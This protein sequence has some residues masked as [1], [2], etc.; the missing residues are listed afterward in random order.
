MKIAI[1]GAGIAGLACAQRLA[2]GGHDVA[3]FERSDVPG[4]RVATMRTELGG[5]D[6][7][8]QYFTIR[9]PLFRAAVDAW[10]RAGLV[11]PWPV[12]VHGVAGPGRTPSHAPPGGRAERWV[13]VPGMS[14]IASALADGIDVRYES[15]IT[16]VDRDLGGAWSLTCAAEGEGDETV[17]EGPFDA[18]VAAVPAEAAARWLPAGLRESVAAVTIEPC[19]AV[20]VGFA[21]PIAIDRAAI[22]DAA[23]VDSGRLA[24]IAREASKPGRRPGERWTLHAPSGWSIEHFD[25]DR[26][27]VE[28][29][30]VTAFHD[31]TGTREQPIYV[32]GYRWRHALAR[33]S[34]GRDHLWDASLKFG[35]CGD[36]CCGHRVEDAWVSG[37]TLAD[38]IGA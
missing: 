10:A 35:A 17:A 11:A 20:M 14:A 12:D 26:E 9:S 30:L 22:G 4:G 31:V 2:D 23:F 16:S 25:D 15:T 37:R 8:A 6:H 28:A 13:G 27:D 34:L 1:V 36:W 32:H 29:K 18:I 33:A 38:A 7:G 3:V 21:E 19:W 24:W 5:F